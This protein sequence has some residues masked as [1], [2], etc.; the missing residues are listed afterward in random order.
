MKSIDKILV[1]TD[2]S[3]PSDLAVRQAMH[4]AR[5]VGA[6]LMIVHA[7]AVTAAQS[8]LA[9]S[10]HLHSDVIDEV[11][12]RAVS[13]AHRQLEELYER[14]TGQGVEVSTALVDSSPAEGVCNAAHNSGADLVVV[15]S[16][17]RSGLSRFLIGSVAEKIL[18]TWD[19]DILLSRSAA[20]AGGFRHLVVGT[21][22]SPLCGAAVELARQVAAR[23][24]PV[25]LVHSWQVPY[26]VSEYSIALGAFDGEI[27]N[28][29]RA[30][31]DQWATRYRDPGL[32]VRFTA[33]VGAPAPTL[34]DHVTKVGAD[35]LVLGSHDRRGVGRLLLGSVAERAARHAPCSV[36]IAR[37][38]PRAAV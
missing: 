26:P 25:E 14:V 30:Q 38:D 23:G 10:A 28:A 2:F 32:D 12:R 3:E 16:H 29:V 11:S 35:L 1:A 34:V 22:F 13:D 17:G 9:Q 37:G 8:I 19:G 24:A 31:G 33:L 15:G 36:L 27:A 6:E 4:L 7:H 18:R 5:H 21:D 20:G